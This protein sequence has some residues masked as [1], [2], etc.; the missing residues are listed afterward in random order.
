MNWYFCHIVWS[1][2]KSTNNLLSFVTLKTDEILTWL[3]I[4]NMYAIQPL[5]WMYY[6]KMFSVMPIKQR[7]KWLCTNIAY[8]KIIYEKSK[9]Y[10][11][12]Q[13]YYIQVLQ[14]K[15]T[16]QWLFSAFTWKCSVLV[17][18]KFKL[19]NKKF[20]NSNPDPDVTVQY[21]PALQNLNI[22]KLS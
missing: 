4:Q 1:K 11:K 6:S 3:C 10:F 13:K 15:K 8:Y 21:T 17:P 2:L 18:F 20:T 12:V 7:F 16:W 9:L 19:H 5:F 14:V 22:W